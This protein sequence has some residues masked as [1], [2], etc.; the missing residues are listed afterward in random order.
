LAGKLVETPSTI[1]EIPKRLDRLSTLDTALSRA[2]SVER[3]EIEQVGVWTI[4]AETPVLQHLKGEVV[5]L[6][7][8]DTD[9]KDFMLHTTNQ[10]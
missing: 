1:A 6:V 5:G 3:A 8:V 2:V 9:C 4:L 7:F 10:F